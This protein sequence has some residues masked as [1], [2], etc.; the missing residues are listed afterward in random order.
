MRRVVEFLEGSLTD[1]HTSRSARTVLLLCACSAR[2]AVPLAAQQCPDGSPPPCEARARA[3]ARV[4]PPAPSERGRHFLVL[5]FRNLSHTPDLEWLVEGSPTLLGDALGRWQEIAVV[6]DDRLFPALR[7]SGVV[8][9]SVVEPARVRRIA[10]ETGGWTAVTG[11]VLATAGRVRVSA[12]ATDVVT[13]RVLVS[14]AAEVGAAEDVRPAYERVGADL[15]RASGLAGE[16]LDLAA[17][18]THSLD[19]YRAYI[20][21]LG[22]YRHAEYR[23]AEEAFL[24]AVRLDSSFAQ[25]YAALTGTA[26]FSSPELILVA[27]SPAYRYAERAAALASRLPPDR[28][29]RARAV[30]DILLGHLSESRSIL[31]RLVAR[32]SADADALEALADL[33]YLDMILVTVGGRQRPRGSLNAAAR[34]SKRVLDLDPAR[35]NRYLVLAQVYDMA[36]GDLPGIL[37]AF[38]E[39]GASFLDMFKNQV[40][41]VFVPV[42]RD[43]LEVVPAEAAR[44]F[45]PES[46]AVWQQNARD[47][48]RTWVGRWLVASPGDAEAHRELARIEELDGHIP[49]AL[50]SL[51]TAESLGV[52]TRWEAVAARRMVLLA[53]MGRVAEARRLA[54]SLASATYFDS[55][56]PIPSL[57]LEGPVWAFQLFLLGGD[58][59]R[60]EAVLSGQSRGLATALGAD[61]A[62]AFA[63]AGGI[64][65]GAGFR[66]YYLTVVP[67]A[68]RLEALDSALAGVGR[69]PPTNLAA[70]ALPQMLRLTA[71]GA[72]PPA[73]ARLAARALDAAFGLAAR[74][75]A[76]IPLAR[77]LAA[78]AVQAD[79]ALAARAAAAPWNAP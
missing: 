78:V 57:K 77:Q 54:D 61:S 75:P 6:P 66:P 18:T 33:E 73:R 64:L 41:R 50:R 70:R 16:T 44:A 65:A 72:D 51:A 9:G 74:D 34:L 22:H 35:R 69:A 13:G 45:A 59:V 68:L 23:R 27:G 39:E 63:F 4:K 21:G 43:S 67:V 1:L 52:E 48:A 32:D 71:P 19:A 62:V 14:A 53:K 49:A 7:R 20:R 56:A 46:V 10:E 42:L 28:R 17:A 29:D 3:A 37:P 24:E 11:E 58:F 25:A 15:L 55:V 2:A 40:P 76:A 5:P 31:E 8:A 26:L 12:R 47:I 30:Y 36:G 60:A 38:R 79:G